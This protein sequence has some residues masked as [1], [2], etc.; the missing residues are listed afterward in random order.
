MSK[1]ILG[2]WLTGKILKAT[3][4]GQFAGGLDEVDTE[5]MVKRLA[6]RNISTIWF[7]SI[8]RNLE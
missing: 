8:E 3:V 7:F 4:L 2:D 1:R 5:A 6:A